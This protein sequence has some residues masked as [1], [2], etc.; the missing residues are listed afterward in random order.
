MSNALT[1]QLETKSYT[2]FI[3]SNDKISGTNNNAQFNINWNDFLPKEYDTY[4][5]TFSFQT[6][7]GYYTDTT[8]NATDCSMNSGGYNLKVNVLSSGTITSGQL[9]GGS[10]A[11]QANTYI[12]SQASGTTGGIGN[13]TV[14]KPFVSSVTTTTVNGQINYSGCKIVMD[15]LGRS[16]SFDTAKLGQS[17]TLGYAQRD[18]ASSTSTSNSFSTFYLQFA[19]KTISRPNQNLITFSFYNLNNNFLL[20]DTDKTGNIK[21][22]M[23]SWNLILEFI[24]VQSS[25]NVLDKQG[26]N[27]SGTG[28]SFSHSGV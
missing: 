11:I 7:G 15:S 28:K 1:N 26:V 6:G 2:L 3:S 14:S 9:I 22:D 12:V 13:Y 16:Y 23:S 25:L 19:P 5:M 8:F 10:N 4:K 21:T 18:M 24:P 17:N 27:T 20:T